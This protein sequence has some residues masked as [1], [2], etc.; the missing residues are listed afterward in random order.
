[1]NKVLNRENLVTLITIL[2]SIILIYLG[3][4]HTSRHIVVAPND[5]NVSFHR[6]TTENILNDDDMGITFTFY[7]ENGVEQTAFMSRAIAD[8]LGRVS[9][10]QEIIVSQGVGNM[11]DLPFNFF[12][13]LRLPNFLIMFAL[14]LGAVILYGRKKGL[15]SVI[16]LLITLATL[17]LVFLPAILSRMNVYLW[18]A[19]CCL[20][21]VTT[22]LLI[23]YGPTKKT[24]CA[25]IGILIGLFIATIIMFFFQKN[26]HITGLGVD[27]MFFLNQTF[28]HAPLDIRAILFSL[29]ILSCLGA[30]MDVGI[31]IASAVAELKENNEDVTFLQLM[32]SGN[33]IG[34]DINGTMVNTLVLAFIGTSFI[35]FISLLSFQFDLMTFL[36]G[37]GF[38]LEMFQP[39]IGSFGILITLP[40]TALVS[41]YIYD[42]FHVI[43][44]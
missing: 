10:G 44:D 3:H 42:R 37:E 41:A 38:I 7:D 11:L 12:D 14:F 40:I 26:L 9:P 6:V 27:N 18:L 39:L 4:Q 20:F 43:K 15:L 19:I 28:Q 5:N 35:N 8:V 34:R 2:V 23:V 17:F 29:I 33:N 13:Y 30:V 36:N 32:K 21:I 22:T 16:A 31:S 1:M 25:G 24:L